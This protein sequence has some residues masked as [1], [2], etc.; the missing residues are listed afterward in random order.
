MPA[1]SKAQQK[2]MGAA[3]AAKRAGTTAGLKGPAKQVVR[4]LTEKQLSDFAG[5][6]TKKL[7]AHVKRK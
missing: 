4:S 1:R 7:P 2:M 3:L 6:K 5:T